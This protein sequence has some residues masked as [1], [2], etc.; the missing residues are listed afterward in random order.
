LQLDGTTRSE[1]YA[2]SWSTELTKLESYTLLNASVVLT[3]KDADWKVT[4]WVKNLADEEYYTYMNG[5]TWTG[6]II[7]APSMLTTYG[8]KLSY[9][10]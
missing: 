3:P 8:V 10:F 7:K 1:H 9:S 6:S 4:S 5:L 2:K